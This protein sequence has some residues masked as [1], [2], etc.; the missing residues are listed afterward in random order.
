M[1]NQMTSVERVIEYASLT[2]EGPLETNTELL[3]NL[4]EG[5]PKRGLITFTNV[6]L[7]YSEASDYVLRNLNFEINEN[8]SN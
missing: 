1:E 4:P 8:V 5:W 2:S 7:K 6:S 3:N